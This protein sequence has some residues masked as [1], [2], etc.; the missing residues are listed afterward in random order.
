MNRTTSP[1]SNSNDD[2]TIPFAA[3]AAIIYS[4]CTLLT[5]ITP[6]FQHPRRYIID[7]DHDSNF[8]VGRVGLLVERH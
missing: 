1:S 2:D 4:T 7:I 5:T 8:G 3:I 6:S